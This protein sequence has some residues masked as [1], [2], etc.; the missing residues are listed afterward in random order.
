MSLLGG[1]TPGAIPGARF[2]DPLVLR[3]LFLHRLIQI[4]IVDS[5][6]SLRGDT[7]QDLLRFFREDARLAVAEEQTT[8]DFTGA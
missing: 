6:S 7:H 4:G 2:L 8:K 5:H 1:H 3:Q